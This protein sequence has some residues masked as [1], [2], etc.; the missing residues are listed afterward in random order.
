MRLHTLFIG[1][2]A[3]LLIALN[4]IFGSAITW[5]LSLAL[6][7]MFLFYSLR[8][9]F[10][11]RLSDN[12]FIQKLYPDL[13][14]QQKEKEI[15]S[16]NYQL[17]RFARLLL[18]SL[19]LTLLFIGAL[20]TVKRVMNPGGD[21]PYFVNTDYYAISNT[22][23]GFTK[24]IDLQ[25]LD[26]EKNDSIASSF[27]IQAN[28]Q[29]YIGRSSQFYTPI[30]QKVDE[31]HARVVNPIFDSEIQQEFSL[32]DAQNQLIIKLNSIS[33]DEVDYQISL[34]SNDVTLL[35]EMNLGDHFD[36][37]IHIKDKP[38][39]KGKSLYN[40][41]IQ[42]TQFNSSKAESKQLLE[43]LLLSMGESYLI[44]NYSVKGESR[45]L[46]FFP[47]H[48]FLEEGWAMKLQETQQTAKLQHQFTLS[49][50]QFFFVGFNQES[51]K[52]K[53]GHLKC[54]DYQIESTTLQHALWFD[55]PPRYS[56]KDWNEENTTRKGFIRFMTDDPNYPVHSSIKAGFL[57]PK[58]GSTSNNTLSGYLRYQ[59]DAPNT[60]LQ[61]SY[62]DANLQQK[63][64]QPVNGKFALRQS[65]GDSFSLFELRDFS[66]HGYS[67]S[68]ILLYIT[69]L[70]LLIL[71]ILLFKPGKGL[72]RIEYIIWAAVFSLIVYRFILW[73]RVATFPPIEQI[74]KHELENTLIRFDFNLMGNLYLPIPLTILW[75]ALA[76][77]LLAAWRTEKI[78]TQLQTLVASWRNKVIFHKQDT[79]RY[80]IVLGACFVLFLLG[81]S[82]HIEIL[83]R[84]FSILVPMAAYLVFSIQHSQQHIELFESS[85]H[86]SKFKRT[87]TNFF[88]FA[89]RSQVSLFSLMTCAFLFMTDKGFGVVFI[90]FLLLKTVVL[91]FLKKTYQSSKVS[92]PDMFFKP[93]N[94]WVYGLIALSIY[95]VLIYFKSLFYYAAAYKLISLLCFLLLASGV[96]L[97][98]KLK[99]YFKYG[100]L[101]FTGIYALLIAVPF[102]RE[103]VDG[104][105]QQRIRHVVYRASIIHQSLDELI[106]RNAYGSFAEQKIMETAENQWFINSYVQKKF[107]T[108]KTINLRPHF[109]GGV[110]FTT[111]TRDVI[112][113]RYIIGEQGSMV[114]YLILLLFLVPLILYLLSFQFKN[115][116]LIYK[117]SYAGIVSLMLV[118]TLC[119]FVWLTSTNR[120]V[121]FGQDLPFLSLTSKLSVLL[122]LMLM[123]VPLLLK[124]APIQSRKLDLGAGA[125]R[126]LLFFGIIGLTAFTTI[127]PNELA[128]EKFSVVI[129]KT[130]QVIE[131]RLNA[132]LSTLQDNMDG[133]SGRKKYTYLQLIEQLKK[134]PEFSTLRDTSDT[135]TKSLLTLLVEKPML[136]F[137]PENPLYMRYDQQ[138]Y[139]ANYNRH[140]Y[141]E[142]PPYESNDIWKGKILSAPNAASRQE[143]LLHINKNE[144]I[145]SSPFSYHDVNSIFHI[146]VAPSSWFA[147]ASHPRAFI[148]V[149][150]A[151]R[152]SKTKLI[153]IDQDNPTYK[154][155][156]VNDYVNEIEPGQLVYTSIGQKPFLISF[157][158]QHANT[159]A[160]SI[161]VNGKDKMVFPLEEKFFWMYH[162]GNAVKTA[163]SSTDSSRH[164]IELTFDFDLS[165]DLAQAIKTRYAKR[166]SKS[167]RFKFAVTVADGDG[168][169]R[170]MLDH[171]DNRKMLNPNDERGIAR[172]AQQHFFFSD[173]RNERDQWGNTN[174][175][176]MYLGPGSSIKPLTTAAITSQLHVE[177]DQLNM[178]PA[179]ASSLNAENSIEQY[180]GLKLTHPWLNSHGDAYAASTDLNSFIARSSNFYQ[181]IMLF[182]GSYQKKDF[183]K[184]GRYSLRN[185]LAAAGRS[186][187]FPRIQLGESVFGLPTYSSKKW[188]HSN[189]GIFYFGHEESL[190]ANG[191]ASNL[192]LRVKDHDKNDFTVSTRN[193][194]NFT[195]SMIYAA[196]QK[197]QSSSYFWSFPEESYFLQMN[198]SM[199]DVQQ[200]F[201]VGLKN[202]TLGGYPYQITPFKMAEMYG[203][204]VSNNAYYRIHITEQKNKKQAWTN[205]STWK[206]GEYSR[207]LSSTVFQGMHQVIYGANGTFKELQSFCNQY[208]DF[209]FYAKTGTID[210]ADDGQSIDSKRLALIITDV[211]LHEGIPDHPPKFYVIYFTMDHARNHDTDMY[212]QILT[213]VMN[214]T[215][216]KNYFAQTHETNLH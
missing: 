166:T 113:A 146:V 188:P 104:F 78:R 116:E 129:D 186:N 27:T 71:S 50:D 105:V 111:Q 70:Y 143:A 155:Q 84:T 120:F 110:D 87:V 185:V 36:D 1:F 106:S 173:T 41:F 211:P 34:Q 134:A 108:H 123:L 181:S 162:F 59:S 77:L 198:R 43:S 160:K 152:T 157:D 183:Y 85:H 199:K 73:W 15:V 86:A 103:K 138:R 132:I 151:P 31:S 121:F 57:F 98:S 80:A 122:P 35:H 170:L 131:Q 42:N 67:Y 114:M 56:L 137:R 95:L 163:Y 20:F 58:I 117:E 61:I 94:S 63:E 182:L 83:V 140:L 115:K 19:F 8:I 203:S 81:K 192:N 64:Y 187:A 11:R 17:N 147:D 74:S 37:V 169:I 97:L 172:L 5:F 82:L 142:L 195:D 9:Q 44:R 72:D 168:N 46:L 60:P 52:M 124:P 112:A 4:I 22:G 33:K 180:A 38:L 47:G 200:N 89:L 68:H 3:L 161:Q 139:V 148:N 208:P 10:E 45:G 207:F 159:F 174:L 66:D 25:G 154:Y 55:Y 127:L 202:T 32:H 205:D 189:N 7:S 30:F 179:L 184:N 158:N 29:G 130:E 109:K 40:L 128:S 144:W 102:T 135:Y 193:R 93:S 39:K 91:S 16:T 201:S 209:Y 165:R 136:A 178:M 100:I 26:Q 194:V 75:M 156:K 164:D 133:A 62:V 90:L 175:L 23:V 21:H 69:L 48:E 177:W 76:T 214:S 24:S 153:W 141:L 99:S 191:L 101:I 126:Y 118:F 171:A 204:L 12:Y 149:A 119:L 215:S 14:R 65:N 212:K 6:L 125:T 167:R 51:H 196:L 210:E 13:I 197:K 206:S 18:P 49:A 107:D 54:S 145:I 190:L 92:L 150:N 216:F 176:N 88:S 96:L 28:Q 2:I 213:Q 53:L 79:I